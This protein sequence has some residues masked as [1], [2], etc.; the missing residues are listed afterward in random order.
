[1]IG[2]ARSPSRVVHRAPTPTQARIVV[3]KPTRCKWRWERELG[4]PPQSPDHMAV[5]LAIRILG[6]EGSNRLHQVLRTSEALPMARQA[7]FDTLKE[8][9]RLSGA[10]TPALRPRPSSC[11]RSSSWTLQRYSVGE[12]ELSDAKAYLTGSFPSTI[13]TP[14]RSPCRCSTCRVLRAAHRG[15]CRLSASA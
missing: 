7:D 11:A 12:R 6:G 8:S 15:S 3:N 13:E 1:M 4:I 10:P 14:T 5:H 2:S 9:R